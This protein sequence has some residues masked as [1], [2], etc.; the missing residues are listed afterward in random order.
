MHKYYKYIH[1]ISHFKGSKSHTAST[2]YFSGIFID[3]HTAGNAAGPW[4][5]G[6]SSCLSHGV[7]RVHMEVYCVGVV[8]FQFQN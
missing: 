6:M 8:I 7:D 2:A 1:N 3:F 4:H 5:K